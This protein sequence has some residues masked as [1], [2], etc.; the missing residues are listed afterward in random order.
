MSNS[1]PNSVTFS[2]DKDSEFTSTLRNR[3]ANYF[4]QKNVTR[5]GNRTMV[6]KT[7]VMVSVYFI[8]FIFIVSGS[9]QSMLLYLILWSLMGLGMAGIGL[10]I[11]HDANH[12][13]YSKHQKFNKILGLLLNVIGGNAVNWKIQHNNLHHKYTNITGVDEDISRVGVLRFSP[14]EPLLKIHKFQYLYAWFLYAL[15]TISWVTKKEFVQLIEYKKRDLTNSYG[16]FTSLFTKLFVWKLFYFAYILAL[17]IIFSAAPLAYVIVGFF[18][19]HFISGFLLSVIFQTAHVVPENEF[20]IPD[21]NGSIDSA[22]TVHQLRTTANFAHKSRFFSWAI[23]GLNYQIE[24]HLFPSICHVHYRNISEIVKATAH[25]YGFP[26]KTEKT[27]LH[28]ILSHAKLLKVLGTKKIPAS[29]VRVA[30]VAAY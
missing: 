24:H 15:M 28:A 14:H 18:I 21:E 1:Y 3:V 30:P 26:Y 29:S 11:M 20:P 13:S 22:W 5:F 8:P 7:I 2:N 23:G 4:K 9:I 27:F 17:P 12:G 10:S 19:M 16:S 25:E 6:L